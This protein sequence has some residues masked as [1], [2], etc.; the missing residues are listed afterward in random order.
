[1][2]TLFEIS[3]PTIRKENTMP[4]YLGPDICR[5]AA[6]ELEDSILHHAECKG[7]LAITIVILNSKGVIVSQHETT[8]T[9]SGLV[10]AAGMAATALMASKD[11]IE[12]RHT[13]NQQGLKPGEGEW[14]ESRKLYPSEVTDA[15]QVEPS[16]TDLAGG[17][18]IR[19]HSDAAVVGAIGVVTDQG[20]IVDHDLASVRPRGFAI[21]A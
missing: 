1:M 14:V 16:F 10:L 3:I 19:D 13:W 20:E 18:L 9:S 7:V 17:V 8:K 21:A 11:T 5:A 6:L 15:R 4:G 12:I 2:N